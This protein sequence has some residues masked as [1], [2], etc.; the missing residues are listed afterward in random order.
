MNRS[1]IQTKFLPDLATR[2][3]GSPD[4]F[5]YQVGVYTAGD[6]KRPVYQS[7]SALTQNAIASAD[8]TMDLLP[9]NRPSTA[10]TGAGQGRAGSRADSTPRSASLSTLGST[11]RSAWQ[12]TASR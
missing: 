4:G 2:H 8:I 7:G 12:R 5:L 3:F 10:R 1:F 9:D 6:A 11:S